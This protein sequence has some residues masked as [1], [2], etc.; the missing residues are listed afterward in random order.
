MK[1]CGLGNQSRRFEG[2]KGA[3]AEGK[4]KWEGCCLFCKRLIY[5]RFKNFAK[6]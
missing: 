6:K 3:K 1:L 5:K 2:G 4:P